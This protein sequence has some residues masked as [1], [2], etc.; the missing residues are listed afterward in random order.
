M[1]STLRFSL[2]LRRA[3]CMQDSFHRRITSGDLK[4]YIGTP[5]DTNETMS[6]LDLLNRNINFDYI[7]W[8]HMLARTQVCIKSNTTLSESC[9][10]RNGLKYLRSSVQ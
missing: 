5:F 2:K 1:E 7:K 9:Q 3:F 8:A 6:K 10:N 4:K